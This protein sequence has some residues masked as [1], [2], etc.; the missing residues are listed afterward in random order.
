M[1]LL[2]TDQ[3]Y[4]SEVSGEATEQE[5]VKGYFFGLRDYEN[6]EASAFATMHYQNMILPKAMFDLYFLRYSIDEGDE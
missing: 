5:V 6:I 2:M 4:F 1:L 3:F